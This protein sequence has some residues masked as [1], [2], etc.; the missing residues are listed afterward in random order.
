MSSKISEIQDLLCKK[1]STKQDVFSI[2]QNVF[3]QLKQ[4]M[5]NIERELTPTLLAEA[6]NVEVKFSEGGSFEAHLKFS[7]DT[8]VIMMHTNIFDFEESHRMNKSAY[9]QE[10]KMREFCGMIQVYNFLSD[11]LKYNRDNDFGYLIARIFINKDNRFFVDGKRPLSFLFAELE[12][13]II[14]TENLRTIIEEAMLFCLHFDLLA[15]PVE[16]INY[17][18]VEQKNTMNLSSGI[19]TGKRLGFV[20][21]SEDKISNA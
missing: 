13:N 4:V 11:S 21:S 5:Q 6:P 16:S 18:S 9:M 17:L 10:D 7:G 15:P 1:A 20:M 14:S 12:K 8:L 2:T 19:P 3:N